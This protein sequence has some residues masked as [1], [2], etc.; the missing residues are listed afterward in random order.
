MESDTLKS[1]DKILDEH[2]LWIMTQG[3]KGKLARLEGW[4]LNGL[5]LE[6]VDLPFAKLQSASLKNCNLPGAN[7]S[8]ADLSKVNFHGA[9]LNGSDFQS[10]KL[11]KANLAYT[12][13]EESNFT[14]SISEN[15]N[16]EEA[17]IEEAIFE[18]ANL[19]GANFKNAAL[20][21]SDMTNANLVKANFEG[22]NLHRTSFEGAN[23]SGANFKNANLS[24]SDM[25]DAELENANF[26]G[27]NLEGTEIFDSDIISSKSQDEGLQEDNSEKP[28]SNGRLNAQL[29]KET[30]PMDKNIVNNDL[31]KNAIR[32]LFIK[33]KSDIDFD[34]IKAICKDQNGIDSIDEI[35]FEHGEIVSRNDKI[36]FKLNFKI[37][38]NWCVLIDQMGNYIISFTENKT[39]SIRPREKSIAQVKEANGRQDRQ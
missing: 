10:A 2:A 32:E 6:S 1:L 18:G 13:C 3:K 31:V 30:L 8:H 36:A 27:A 37:S 7:F 34:G 22:A 39:K 12:E 11:S 5:D 17:E 20:S 21:F 4:N 9:I 19:S 29:A 33:V 14:D 15:V 25:S 24:F 28:P 16:F 35:Q 38:Y 26:E 23:L